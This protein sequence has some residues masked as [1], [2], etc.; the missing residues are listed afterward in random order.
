MK[1]TNTSTR[2]T[3]RN[4]VLHEV[5]DFLGES[6]PALFAGGFFAI[7]EVSVWQRFREAEHV[8]SKTLLGGLGILFGLVVLTAVGTL[9]V[10]AWVWFSHSFGRSNRES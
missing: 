9:C 8:V 3:Q 4:T 1:V 2:K 6:L 10:T 5:F 7:A